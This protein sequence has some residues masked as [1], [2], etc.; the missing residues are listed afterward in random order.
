MRVAG[1]KKTSKYRGVSWDKKS[2]KWR[3]QLIIEKQI[4]FA[5]YFTSEDEAN[6][7]LKVKRF[8]YLGVPL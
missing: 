6:E 2:G 1:S 5:G 3:A 7:A 4:R 8:K